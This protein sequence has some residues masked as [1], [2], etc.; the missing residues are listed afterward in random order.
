MPWRLRPWRPFLARTLASHTSLIYRRFADKHH[1]NSFRTL[2]TEYNRYHKGNVWKLKPTVDNFLIWLRRKSRGHLDETTIGEPSGK[3]PLDESTHIEVSMF[4]VLLG[5][6]SDNTNGWL[7]QQRNQLERFRALP[8]RQAEKDPENQESKRFTRIECME[9]AESLGFSISNTSA[10]FLEDAM[11]S[12]SLAVQ[13]HPDLREFTPWIRSL[14][15]S[16]VTQACRALTNLSEIPAF[17]ITDILLRTPLTPQEL[18]LQLDL[19]L[20]Q[21]GPISV[22]YFNRDS[23]IRQIINNLVFYII[24]HDLALLANFVHRTL[25][26]LTTTKTGY[27]FKILTEKYINTLIYDMA[28]FSL[29]HGYDG[30]VN[31]ETIYSSQMSD[32]SA[33]NDNSSADSIGEYND[34]IKA[35]KILANYLVKKAALSQIGYLGIVLAVKSENSKQ[36]EKL[37][38]AAQRQFPEH[39]CEYHYTNIHLCPTPELLF[40]AFN[41]ATLQYPNSALLWY[42]FV[43]KLMKFDLLT[44]TR[45]HKLLLEIT[46]RKEDLLIS[47]DLILLLLG[48]IDTISG[49]EQFITVLQSASLLEKFKNSILKKYMVLLF[50]HGTEKSVHKPFMDRLYRSSSNI[51]CARYLY[52][53]NVWNTTSCVGVMLNGEVEHQ[54]ENLYDLYRQELTSLSQLNRLGGGLKKHDSEANPEQIFDPFCSPD[55]NIPVYPNEACLVALLR[56]SMKASPGAL[57]IWGKL[58][59]L[60]VAVHEFKKYVCV[61]AARSNAPCLF[62]S[63]RLWRVYLFALVH[64]GYMLELADVIRWWE[65]INFVPNQETLLVLLL[66]LPEE[67]A[68]RHIKHA[69]SVPSGSNMNWPWPTMTQVEFTRHAINRSKN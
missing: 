23:H 64:A 60:Q 32:I 11:C 67:V 21:I 58:H 22:A 10:P 62:P 28:S 43:R 20:R 8:K 46:R 9:Y 2:E 34:V 47:K 14:T 6:H 39:T 27:K 12:L 24:H 31:A 65:T 55:S 1:R 42:I 30:G 41:S 63:N 68:E 50:K 16:N 57:L 3:L 37:F 51:D 59:A 53:K 25:T 29:R 48:P 26:Y 45:S 13:L 35:Q 54:P 15:S 61:D 4:Y 36:A 38:K 5:L 44:E 19:W 69:A 52:S 40:Q 7:E 17:V 49:I 18:H 33:V 56:G 66:A